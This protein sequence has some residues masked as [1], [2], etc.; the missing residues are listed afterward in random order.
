MNQTYYSF[1]SVFRVSFS[2]SKP[3][4]EAPKFT[5]PLKNIE[6]SEKESVV[7]ECKVTGKPTPKIEWYKDDNKVKESKRVKVLVVKDTVTLE[8]KETELDDEGVY[9][10]VATNEVGTATSEAEILVNEAGEKPVF[11]KPLEDVMAVPSEE[12]RFDVRVSGTPEPTVDWFKDDQKIKDEGRTIIIDDEEEDLFS[13]IIE[14]SQPQD[15][16][17]YKCTAINEVG[18]VTCQAELQVQEKMVAPEFTDGQEAGPITIVEEDDLHLE[19]QVQGQP[20]PE[21]DWKKDDKPLKETDKIVIDEKDDNYWIDI[22]GVSLSDSG[23][24]KCEVKSDAGTISR[25]Y[26]VVVEGKCLIFSLNNCKYSGL[27]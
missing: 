15:S 5:Q 6:C 13:L 23:T 12:I 27:P 22:K 24:Y 10:C 19:V 8:F 7:L 16:G 1:N 21:V 14:D 18:E 25:S 11:K 4:G 17:L 26:D 9:K 3:K 2:E 20:R